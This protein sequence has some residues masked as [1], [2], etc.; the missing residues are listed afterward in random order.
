MY[1]YASAH[2]FRKLYVQPLL[3]GVQTINYF[4]VLQFARTN[5]Q[6]S[7]VT[8]EKLGHTKNTTYWE[9]KKKASF[10]F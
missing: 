3:A 7:Q 1:L 6:T 8:S 9:Q 10:F 4:L 5:H 2:F